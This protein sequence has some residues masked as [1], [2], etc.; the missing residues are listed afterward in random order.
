MLR[1]CLYVVVNDIKLTITR[2][3]QFDGVL[4]MLMMTYSDLAG[5]LYF[6]F[7]ACWSFQ[8]QDFLR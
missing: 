2:Q 7:L 8:F 6:W 3:K 1:Y 5:K 4:D